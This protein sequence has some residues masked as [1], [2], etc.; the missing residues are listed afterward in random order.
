MAKTTE[1]Q[2]LHLFGIR[3]HGPGSSWSLVQALNELQP[4]SVLVE[5]PP[6]ADEVLSYIA[7]KGVF[8]PVAL[9][10]YTAQEAS[11]SSFYPFAEF[12][13]EWQAVLWA[14]QNN[15]PVRFIDLPATIQ[16][17]SRLADWKTEEAEKKTLLE[18]ALAEEEKLLSQ[19]AN[20]TATEDTPKQDNEEEDKQ[21]SNP[22]Q[23]EQP[24]SSP[25]EIAQ[26]HHAE[27]LARDPLFHLATL[28]GYEDS[29]AWWNNLIEQN[30]QGSSVFASIEQA[31]SVLRDY[32]DTQRELDNKTADTE[33]PDKLALIDK[34]EQLREQR[35]EA[36]MRLEIAKEMKAVEGEIAVVCGAWHVPALRKKVTLKNDRALLKGLKKTKVLVTWVPWT[37]NRLAT[38]SGYSAGVI[39]P[40]WYRHL[41]QEL[42]R[43]KRVFY[44]AIGVAAKE[45]KDSNSPASSLDVRHLTCGWQAQVAHLMR[46]EGLGADT[47][48]VI[49]AARLSESLAA[50]RGMAIPG[51]P[52]MRDATLSTLCH[53]E[54]TSLALIEEKLIIGETIGVVAESVPQMPLQADLTKWQK[55]LRLKPEQ[56]ERELSIDLRSETGLLKST[57][58]HRLNLINIPWGKLTDAGRSRGSFRERWI[59]GWEPEYAVLLAEAM[60]WGTTI[61]QAASAM[62]LDQLQKDDLSLAQQGDLV[63]ACLL[64]DLPQAAQSAITILQAHAAHLGNVQ[65]LAE[66]VPPLVHVLRYGTARKMPVEALTSLVSGLIDKIHIG[67]KYACRNLDGNAASQMIETLERY[68]QAIQIFEDGTLVESWCNALALVGNDDATALLAGFA[69]RRQYDLSAIDEY[70]LSTLV[71]AALSSAVETREAADWLEGFLRQ[72]AQ[73]LIHDHTLF[74]IINDWLMALDDENFLEIL[75]LLRR[76]T[77]EFDTMER[78]HLFEKVRGANTDNLLAGA[79][80]YSQNDAFEE[81]FPLLKTILGLK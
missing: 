44:Q 30:P 75:P 48:S 74:N 29:E 54:M 71:S 73:I 46:E 3:H 79:G 67:L 39:S 20:T 31:M 21:D 11:I 5:G 28:A 80:D 77:S 33:Q 70:A 13:P 18:Q 59:L 62:A 60:V 17:E 32:V 16:L 45:Q 14:A 22:Y 36:F 37:D 56:L 53:G 58:L 81:A 4:D 43:P 7:H 52:E 72:A 42:N 8:P 38:L 68:D 65:P 40:G 26:H 15:K 51:L 61:E 6:E 23:T 64:A 2:R 1:K 57:L 24:A 76:T 50:L 66:T 12:S 35:R 69:V 47:A 9:L 55:K 49:E 78:Q 34:E 41:W 63:Q 27:Q 10:I 25:E 19:S